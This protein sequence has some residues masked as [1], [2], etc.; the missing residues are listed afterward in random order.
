MPPGEAELLDENPEC[1]KGLELVVVL[2]GSNRGPAARITPGA[3]LALPVEQS[4]GLREI[5]ER[6]D[7]IGA[8]AKQVPSGE[9]CDRRI[10]G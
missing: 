6:L 8:P 10:A 1:A 3:V 5:P 4:T 9:V 7:R 2:P